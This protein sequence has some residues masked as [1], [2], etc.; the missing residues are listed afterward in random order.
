MIASWSTWR[1]GAAIVVR[2]RLSHPYHC[3]LQ[4]WWIRNKKKSGLH[5]VPKPVKLSGGRVTVSTDTG[6]ETRNLKRLCTVL[7]AI[8]LKILK[9]HIVDA[10][11]HRLVGPWIVFILGYGLVRL[12]STLPASNPVWRLCSRL[13][14]L[15]PP[16]T[17]NEH[18]ARPITLA[19]DVHMSH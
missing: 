8:N 12:E 13:T 4:R 10:V 19:T 5:H 2:C 3:A 9:R 16:I 18:A 6:G 7:H 14:L 11:R 15:I 17:W 1:G